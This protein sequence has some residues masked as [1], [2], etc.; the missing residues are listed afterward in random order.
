M[1]EPTVA[2][3][4]DATF[5]GAEL[6]RARELMARFEAGDVAHAQGP[7]RIPFAVIKIADGS[8]DTLAEAIAHAQRDWRDTLL[9][10][11]CGDPDAH[12]VWARSVL[13]TSSRGRQQRIAGE[14]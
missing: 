1:S 10:A 9:W 2:A 4:L 13:G 14:A 6:E 3:V 7:T 5:D 11:E 8:A 12:A